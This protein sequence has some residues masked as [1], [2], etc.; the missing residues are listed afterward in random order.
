M[1]RAMCG[2]QPID[3]NRFK[4][5]MLMLGLN[6]A[7]DQL[8]MANSIGWYGYLLRRGDGHVLRNALDFEIECQQKNER[9]MRTWKK[10]VEEES[11]KVGLRREDAL[12]RSKWSV[13]V[14]QIAAGFR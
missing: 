14:I 11:V 3:I 7:I 1:V 5:L 4:D 10:Q 9:Q 13:S 8:A 12:Y 2:V 6:K